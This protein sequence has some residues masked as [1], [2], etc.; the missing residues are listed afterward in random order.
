MVWPV[1][2]LILK[3]PPLFGLANDTFEEKLTFYS[4]LVREREARRLVVK[5][6]IL[7]KRLARR[8]D[9]LWERYKLR[10]APRRS[11]SHKGK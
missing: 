7:I 3:A 2:K 4:N 9:D 5:S 1:L 11:A 6:E 8:Y 10:D